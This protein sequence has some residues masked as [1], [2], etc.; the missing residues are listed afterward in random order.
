MTKHFSTKRALLASVL[1]LL[2]CVSM[3]VGSTF[4][5]FTDSATT[6]VNTIQSGKLDVVLEMW[7]GEK[8]VDAEGKT[9]E[10]VKGAMGKDQAVIWEPGCTYELPKLRISNGGNLALKFDVIITGIG[11][12][13]KLNEVIEWSYD[14]SIDYADYRTDPATVSE[15]SVNKAACSKLVP[16]DKA[17]QSITISYAYL[18]ISGH[19][20]E[21]AGNEYQDLTIDGIS[22]TVLATQTDFESDSNNPMY[23]I[24]ADGSPDNIV[25]TNNAEF[26]DALTNA[27][28]GDVIVLGS[29]NYEVTEE[30][31]TNGSFVVPE[32]ANVTLD[33]GGQDLAT[34][35]SSEINEPTLVNKG[36][37]TITNATVSNN[38]ATN[39]DNKNVAAVENAGGTLTLKDCT[40]TN[41]SPTSGGAYAV[42]VTGGKVVL[43]NCV[44]DGNRGGIAVSGDGV[45]EMKGGRVEAGYYYPLY[46]KDN[47][48]ASFDDVDFLQDGTKARA[49]VYVE[50]ST[51][52]ATFNNCTFKSVKT[53]AK[54][55]VSNNTANFTFTG[56]NTFTNVTDPTAN[57]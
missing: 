25:V 54:F 24:N 55:E 31:K 14:Y 6:A 50:G 49:M 48:S 15:I 1:S 22:I 52:T 17:D 44:V 26:K 8:W 42:N 53:G 39:V 34:N 36:N 40:L 19:M 51:A 38:N 4:A 43:E 41:T 7:D 2:L 20:L 28:I 33:M 13:A 11:G 21:T 56:T 57:A 27:E 47:A 16:A 3:L 29:G 46:L 23:D 12:D 37:L 10:F 9:L 45:V 5:W 35:K 18:T 32:G 30:I